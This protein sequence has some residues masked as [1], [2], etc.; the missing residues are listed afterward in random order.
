MPARKASKSKKSSESNPLPEM[1]KLLRVALPLV[2][3]LGFS[4]ECLSRA[5]AKAKIPPARAQALFPDLPDDLLAH[6]ANWADRQML[7]E[8]EQ[9]AKRL[10]RV[11]DKVALGVRL[12]LEALTPYKEAVREEL[13]ELAKPW[14]VPQA[15]RQLFSTCDLI[16]TCAGDRSTDYNYYT[17]RTLLMGVYASTTLRWLA[18]DTTDHTATWEFL[19]RRI[20]NVLQVGKLTGALKTMV[21]TRCA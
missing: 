14:H 3:G 11:R 18:D 5:A 1:D 7:A 10:T 6:L 9:A 16:W 15:T 13:R 4:P 17:K 12:R 8:Y 20:E 21:K 19:A 2:P